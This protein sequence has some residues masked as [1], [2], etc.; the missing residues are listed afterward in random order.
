MSVF[1]NK[2]G[3]K[4]S[5][6][7]FFNPF[8][9]SSGKGFFDAFFPRNGPTKDLLSGNRSANIP[10]MP[11]FSMS[12]SDANSLEAERLMEAF[13]P[14]VREEQERRHPGWAALVEKVKKATSLLK[15]Y[16]NRT[17]WSGLGVVEYADWCFY[18][19]ENGD[20]CRLVIHAD[21]LPARTPSDRASH[22]RMLQELQEILR[23]LQYTMSQEEYTLTILIPL[24]EN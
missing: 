14:Y 12:N 10:P 19:E 9:A 15:H 24:S 8:P 2:A 23:P 18:P 6:L 20:I 21:L 22:D 11:S 5:S 7:R 4:H 17:T 16:E 3:G 13:V 1:R